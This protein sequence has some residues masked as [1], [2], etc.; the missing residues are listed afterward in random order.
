M[1][2][3][4]SCAEKIVLVLPKIMQLIREEVRGGKLSNLTVPQFRTMIFFNNH[5]GSALTSV[6]EHIG[7]TMPSMSKIVDGLVE[8]GLLNRRLSETDRRKVCITLTGN[9]ASVLKSAYTVAVEHISSR[10]SILKQEEF[11][12]IEK[13]LDL[14]LQ[15]F[16]SP[17]QEDTAQCA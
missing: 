12:I 17:Q 8:R 16:M 10:L 3:N 13:A 9:G 11:A 1:S 5:P 14:L 6:A 4:L 7:L 15:V 2:D